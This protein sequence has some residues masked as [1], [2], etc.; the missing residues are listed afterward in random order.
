MPLTNAGR[1]LITSLL[2]GG[3]GTV[4]SNAN[5]YLGVGDDATAFSASQTDLLGAS[6]FRK[7]MDATFPTIATNILTFQSTF[8]TSEANFDWEE[9]GVFNAST[10]GVMVSRKAETLGTKANT[11][12]WQFTVTL[13]VSN[14]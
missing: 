2:I 3:A 14:P 1:N 9:W 11:Q 7:A 6:K 4:F 5:A 10:S 8:S 12:S 13:T